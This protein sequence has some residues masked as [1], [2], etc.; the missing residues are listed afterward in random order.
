MGGREAL[1][2]GAELG[3][4][5]TEVGDLGIGKRRREGREGVIK[6]TCTLES[7]EVDVARDRQGAGR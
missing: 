2:S 7:T 4:L 3:K 1:V 6:V 5:G